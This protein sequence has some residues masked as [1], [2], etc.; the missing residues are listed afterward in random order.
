MRKIC[1]SKIVKGTPKLEFIVEQTMPLIQISLA[2]T[3]ELVKKVSTNGL[4]KSHQE[5]RTAIV[6]TTRA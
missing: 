4:R 6:D 2:S 3:S 5:H 1:H